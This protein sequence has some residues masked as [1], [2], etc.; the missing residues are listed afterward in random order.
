M[1]SQKYFL[2]YFSSLQCNKTSFSNWNHQSYLGFVNWVWTTKLFL[3]NIQESEN[4]STC[5]SLHILVPVQSQ[6]Q[7]QLY[8]KIFTVLSACT[9]QFRLLL[10]NCQFQW[11]RK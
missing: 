2:F 4:S 7:A 8:T 11:Q 1:K 10:K 9:E 5:I 6:Q 3:P